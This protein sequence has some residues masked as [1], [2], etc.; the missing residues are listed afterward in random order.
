MHHAVDPAI[1][2]DKQAELGDVADLAFDGRSRRVIGGKGDPRILLGLLQPERNPALVRIDLEHLDLD[3]LTGRDDLAGVDVLLGP[4]HLRHMD[5]PLDAGLELDEGAVVGDVGDRTLEAGARRVFGGDALPRIGFELLD[6]EADA[7]GFRIDAD[8]LHLHRVAD[9]HDLARMIDAPPR[10]VGDVKQAVDAAEVDEGAVIGD[11]LDHAVDDL[12]LFETSHDLAALL[13]AGLFQ[14]G[15]ARD[16]DIAAAAVHLEDLEGL[17]HVHERADVADRANVHLASG[18]EGHGAVEID[19]EPAFDA[20]ED[21]ALDALARLVLLFEPGPALLAAGLLA[22][23]H[24][25]A[26]RVLDPLEIDIDFVADREVG[27]PARN[28]NLF[29]GNAPFGLQPD[30]VDGDVF[31][32]SDDGAL[33][34]A[35]FLERGSGERLFKQGRE[36]VTARMAHTRLRLGHLGSYSASHHT[37]SPAS[38]K[39]QTDSR[40]LA[41]RACPPGS[42]VR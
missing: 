1:E 14:H 12:A 10:H 30:I 26:G 40:N 9:I 25:L 24:R 21:H 8:D 27:R 42:S 29:E 41:E 18:E 4:T 37:R 20:V 2:S 23:Q 35:A 19:G 33:D 38:L 22:R 16:D 34:H 5:Q 7:L 32:D 3:L 39:A 6:A 36:F 15:T 13:G 31:F 17:R 11:V 28:A